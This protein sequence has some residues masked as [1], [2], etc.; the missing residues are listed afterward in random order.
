MKMVILLIVAIAILADGMLTGI[1]FQGFFQASNVFANI[2]VFSAG[3]IVT[4]IVAITGWIWKGMSP[5][6]LKVLWI[7]SVIVDVYTTYVATIFYV[8]QQN[9]L[10]A[11]PN[12]A[13][14]PSLSDLFGMGINT[15]VQVILVL[16]LPIILTGTSMLSTYIIENSI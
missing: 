13:S 12:I 11:S 6:P 3:F 8:L 10:T 1:A 2:L 4:G 16:I 5:W 7:F 15:Q 14:I 9:P